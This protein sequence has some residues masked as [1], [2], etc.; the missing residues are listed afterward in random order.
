MAYHPFRHLGLKV[1]AIALAALLWL[2]VAGEH[3]VERSLRVPLEFRNVPQRLEIVGDPPAT[4]DVR[5]RGSSALLG[6]LD[7]GE[8]V[9][10]LDL[11]A[12]RPGSRLFHLRNDEV[13]A[14]FGVEVAQVMPSTLPLELRSRRAASCRCPVDPTA[15]PRPASWSAAV[16][17]EPATVSRRPGEPRPSARGGDDRAGERRRQPRSASAT[18]SPSAWPTPR[19]G[20]CTPQSA[21][22]IVEIL[23]A[24]VEREL[25]GVPVRWRNLGGGTA[26]AGRAD[27]RAGHR[28]RAAGCAGRPAGRGDRR[29]RGPCRA[30]GRPV[31]SPGPGR[32]V[33]DLRR[34][35]DHPQRR[36]G[37][38]QVGSHG[39]ASQQHAPVRAPTN[40]VPC[41]ICSEP[42]ASAGKAGEYPLD[43][44]TVARLG[45]ALVRAMRRPANA[46]LRFIVG[47]D[48]RESGEWI[49]RELAR[50]AGSA[51]ATITSA[52]VIPTPAIA[53]VTREMGFDAGLVISASH[54]PFQDNGIKVFSGRA[55]SSPRRSSARSRRSSPP[56]AGRVPASARRAASTQVDVVDAYIA[57][58]R[59]RAAGSGAPGPLPDRRSM[60]PT[61]RRPTVAPRLFDELG[62]DVHLLGV[63]AGRAQHQPR[64]RLDPPRGAR[65]S[66]A[67]ARLPHGRRVRRRRR[68]RD[69]RRCRP[70]R[71]VDGDA[72][73][74]MCA[75]T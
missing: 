13:R 62:F 36:R 37:D 24:P 1:L 19:S 39:A 45:A 51:G 67:R 21:T 27:A 28:P 3:V 33:R 20:S 75:A 60:R 54:N 32:S 14:P 25:T 5:L 43:H 31:Q 35:H 40:N 16:T 53:Y 46:P 49:E 48:T 38:D 2:T 30:R 52:G 57:H 44:D 22:V 6:R 41:R 70:D 7:P 8:I 73:L 23:P 56:T 47:R 63:H 17:S 15:S 10:V 61:A 18:W 9:A 29:L 50:G 66:R 74:L 72:V 55:R 69:L 26:G 65:A 68:P 58:A 64:L 12:A 4:V 11:S 34:Q 42:T 71:V 59:L